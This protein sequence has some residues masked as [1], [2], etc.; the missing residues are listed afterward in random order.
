MFICYQLRDSNLSIEAE[1]IKD[2]FN[3]T[4]NFKNKNKPLIH[5]EIFYKNEEEDQIRKSAGQVGEA[6]FLIR[7]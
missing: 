5:D 4:R 6:S 3:P 2:E 7:F 1:D